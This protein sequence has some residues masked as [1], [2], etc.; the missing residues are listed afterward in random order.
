MG[1]YQVG[2]LIYIHEN[3][4]RGTESPFKIFT[5]ISCGSLNASFLAA[6]SHNAV[7]DIYQLES[8]WNQFHVPEYHGDFRIRML[9]Y[10]LRRLFSFGKNK[11][12]MGSLLD[13]TPMR[14]IINKGFQRKDLEACF[15]KKSTLGLGVSATE[16]SS[17]S[18]VWFLDGPNATNWDRFHSAGI[19]ADIAADHVVASCSVP[20]LLP[21]VQIGDYHYLDGGM[22][23][24][25]PLSAAI[26]M[27]ST[28]ILCLRTNV[29]LTN[30]PPE[31]PE[32]SK[33]SIGSLSSFLLQSVAKDKIFAETEQIKALNRVYDEIKELLPDDTKSLGNN[34]I[35]NKNFSL[36]NYKPISIL[37]L[38]PSEEPSRIFENFEDYTSKGPRS[39]VHEFGFH[40]EYTSLLTSLGYADAKAK[41][42]ELETF[43]AATPPH[44]SPGAKR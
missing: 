38:S 34:D 5:G 31:A 3:F 35:F 21:P 15:R 30:K 32:V 26:A 43:F 11:S 10:P 18:P 41:H 22:N 29:K 42:D 2:A 4:C 6:H 9:L 16:M 13:P 27:G 23:L 33:P 25:R 40:R 44:P 36:A 39:T 17:G 8:L 20:V 19:K 37:S 1:A 14:D 28:K 12:S 7:E 24:S